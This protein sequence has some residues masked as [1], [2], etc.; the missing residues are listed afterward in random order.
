[1]I[2]KK[3]LFLHPLNRGLFV[4]ASL[5]APTAFAEVDVNTLTLEELLKV[6]VITA[7]KREQSVDESPAFVE[8]ITQSDLKRRGYKDL[9]YLL[10][11][12][13]GIQ[14]IR[15]Q[16]DNY[17]NTIW[18]GVRH[19]IGSSHLILVDGLKFNH[20]YTNEAEVL[21]TIPLS[22]IKHVE[23]VYGPGSVAYGNDAV[24]GIINVITLS[25]SN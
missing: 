21:A 6:K 5:V 9:S 12:I 14:V 3:F 20:L 23:I 25:G 7:S 10:D 24:V 4:I 18:R 16:S 8:I 2:K 17:V 13:S 19:T 15:A 22:N 11:D 1:M